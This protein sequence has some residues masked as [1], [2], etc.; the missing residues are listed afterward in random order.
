MQNKKM[1]YREA[2]HL[3]EKLA[4]ILGNI[5]RVASEIKCATST[6]YRWKDG[7]KKVVDGYSAMALKEAAI[8]HG[9][10]EA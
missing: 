6:V 9:I 4:T 5:E 1:N 2:W 7:G 8:K 3:A 10:L